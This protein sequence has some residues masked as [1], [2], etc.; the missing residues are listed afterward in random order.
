MTTSS[1]IVRVGHRAKGGHRAL[2]CDRGW[3]VEQV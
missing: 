3:F 2:P 1:S